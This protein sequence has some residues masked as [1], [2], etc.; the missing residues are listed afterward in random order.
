MKKKYVKIEAAAVKMNTEFGFH[1]CCY[2][3]RKCLTSIVLLWARCTHDVGGLNAHS[4]R[5]STKKENTH[6]QKWT[7]LNKYWN[8]II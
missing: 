6:A 8:E 3:S 5:Y 2:D 4:F 7:D 1:G